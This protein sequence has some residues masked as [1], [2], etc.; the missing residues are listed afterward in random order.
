MTDAKERANSFIWYAEHQGYTRE[1]A[2]DMAAFA[3]DKIIN[4]GNVD[5]I[6][7]SFWYDVMDELERMKS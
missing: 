5:R 3:V 7:E 1:I 4:Y 6:E 2:I